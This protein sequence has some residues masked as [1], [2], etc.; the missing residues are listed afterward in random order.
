MGGDGHDGAGAIGGEDVIRD[1]DGNALVGKRI[2]GISAG[3]D[4][5]LLVLRREAFDFGLGFGL[6]DIGVDI[7][8]P[9]LRGDLLDQLVL[10]GDHHEGR[11]EDGIRPRGEHT[12]TPVSVNGE[13][14]I[15]AFAATDPI[16][17]HDPNALGPAVELAQ[18]IE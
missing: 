1:P 2:D 4:A 17:L 18:V 5:G 6:L 14:Q 7:A 12:Q 8:P 16:G 15:G 3:K 11:A 10:R 13:L 9:I